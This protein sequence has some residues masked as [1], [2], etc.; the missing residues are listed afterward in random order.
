MAEGWPSGN[1]VAERIGVS[2]D[3]FYL[4]FNERGMPGHKVGRLW[5]FNACAVGARGLAGGDS[6]RIEPLEN[7][8]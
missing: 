1:A 8:P 4:G 2:K 3:D 6:Q 7:S 5:N